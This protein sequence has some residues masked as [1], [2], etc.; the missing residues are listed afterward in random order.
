M[1]NEITLPLSML[2]HAGK[3][4]GPGLRVAL[5]ASSVDRGDPASRS[6]EFVAVTGP[7]T[8]QVSAPVLVV[9]A[10][11]LFWVLAVAFIAMTWRAQQRLA[12][13]ISEL[14]RRLTDETRP[15]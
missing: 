9:A 5:Q 12:A 8:E 14:E 4:V 2:E 6:S 13:R 11:A 15:Q 7:G 3:A 10:Y 1:N